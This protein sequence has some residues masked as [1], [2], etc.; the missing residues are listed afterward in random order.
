MLG[1]RSPIYDL[2]HLQLFSPESACRLLENA[3][4]YRVEVSPVINCY[5]LHYWVKLLPIPARAGRPLVTLLKGRALGHVPVSVPVGNMAVVGY[6]L[7]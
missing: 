6:R 4:F 1:A 3:G 7:D 2:E 5:P